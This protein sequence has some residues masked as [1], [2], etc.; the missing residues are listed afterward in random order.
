VIYFSGL[1]EGDLIREEIPRFEADT[2]L[3]VR[4]EEVPYDAVRPKEVASVKSRE[5]IYDVMFVDDIWLYEFARNNYVYPLDEFIRRDHVDMD[6]F[7]PMC[8]KAEADLDGKTWLIPQRADVQVLYYRTDLFSDAG[9]RDQFQQRYSA[10]LKV[11]E[12]WDDYHRLA[13]FFSEEGKKASP[14]YF[15]TAE[16]LKRPHFAFE[17]F[18]M[19]YWSVAD[20]NFLDDS[21][22]PL[23]NTPQGT[24]ALQLLVNVRPFAAPGSA[25]ASHD[26]TVATFS[27]GKAALAPEWYAFYPVFK[28]GK[29]TIHDKFGVAIVP[30]VRTPDGQ[31]RHTPSIGGGS[32]GI[33]A[34]SA[35]KEGAWEFIKRVTSKE[36]MAKA[37]VRGAIVTRQSAYQN[38]EVEKANPGIPVYVQ[39]LRQSWLRPRTDRFVELESAVGLAVSQSY[40]GELSPGEALRR[41]AEQV[42]DIGR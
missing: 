20:K 29:T 36:F 14:S 35:N 6:D 12:T 15:G 13:Q 24:A 33:A 27:S 11:P 7:F 5:G 1:P 32:L 42:K 39:S 28:D 34:N 40:V 31:I 17:F 8:R 3:T 9:L 26:E 22:Q 41:A 10:E 4:F 25:N 18:A 21:G 38:P 23:F 2:G 19:R 37:A 16:T 30:G